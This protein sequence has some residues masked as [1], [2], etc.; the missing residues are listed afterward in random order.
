MR[1]LLQQNNTL[2]MK[3]ILFIMLLAVAGLVTLPVEAAAQFDLSRAINAF[4]GGSNDE[5]AEPADPEP[6]PFERIAADAPSA[7]EALGT[8]VYHSASL[9]YLGDNSFADV[10]LAP[11]EGLGVAELEGAGITSGSSTLTLRRGGNGSIAHGEYL[12]DGRYRYNAENGSLTIIA[13]LEGVEV[14]CSGFM[15]LIGGEL[16]VMVDADEALDAFLDAYPEQRNDPTVTMASSLLTNFSEVY[17]AI[18]F[19]R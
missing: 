15:T 18:H 14:S 1:S 17:V 5:E 3:R 11:L 6:T 12:F 19:R 7:S 4:F 16:T 8:W 9:E 2:I 13:E 10:A